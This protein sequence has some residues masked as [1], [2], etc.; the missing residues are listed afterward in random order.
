[1]ATT[2]R[3]MRWTGGLFATALVAMT[4]MHVPPV[5]GW[6]AAHGHHGAGVCPLGYGG[7]PVSREARRVHDDAVRGTQPARARPA[8]GFAL[9]HTTAPELEA[10]AAAHGVTCAAKHGGSLVECAHVPGALVPGAAE[11]ALTSVWFQFGARG[12]LE[13]VRTVRRDPAVATVA[14]AFVRTE[15]EL[16]H[17]AGAP[18]THD[19]SAASDVLANGTLRQAMVE[20]RFTDY[21]AVVRATNMG[22]GFLLTEEYATLVD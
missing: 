20:Y 21:R 16:T 18:A 12:T 11:L 5:R 10:W 4:V 17:A 6:L 2:R 7:A 22:D 14:A 13:T 1:M 19:G 3:W 8:L 15:D 9:D